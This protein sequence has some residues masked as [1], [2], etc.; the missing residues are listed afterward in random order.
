MRR[1]GGGVDEGREGRG[2]GEGDGDWG[3]DLLEGGLLE[4]GLLERGW[5][6]EGGVKWQGWW[7]GG[8]V[9]EGMMKEGMMEWFMS[10]TLL[11]SIIDINGRSSHE[12]QKNNA[13]SEIDQSTV[14]NLRFVHAL[15]F[16]RSIRFPDW[17]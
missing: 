10:G 7:V 6:V 5:A 8:L 1:R 13:A 15:N 17:R 14:S 11:P 4:G 9:K 3:G 12:G 16:E 2:G